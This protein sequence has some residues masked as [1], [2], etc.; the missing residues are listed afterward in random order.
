MKIRV[1]SHLGAVF[2]A[3][4]LS[5][6]VGNISDGGQEAASGG[7]G[8]GPPPG[9]GGSTASGSGGTKSGGSGGTASGGAGSGG[10][11]GTGGS[12]GPKPVNLSGAP[13]YYRFVRLSN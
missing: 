2:V 10:A 4:S 1:I 9:S 6:C 12:F 8:D 3:A 13:K 5:G 11:A 7:A